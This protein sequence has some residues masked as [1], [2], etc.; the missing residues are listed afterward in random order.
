MAASAGGLKVEGVDRLVK[1]LASLKRAAQGKVARRA[2]GEGTKLTL[3]GVKR[4]TP[5][6]TGTLRASQGRKQKTYRTSG[7]TIGWVGP[8]EGFVRET[9]KGRRDPRK[10]AHLVEF[11]PGKSFLRRTIDEEKVQIQ[12]AIAR[13]LAEG[14]EQEAKK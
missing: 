9:P 5:R 1:K 12:A 2:M 13:K 4:R 14:I 8:R 11:A 7:V 3:K 6:D 10:Y